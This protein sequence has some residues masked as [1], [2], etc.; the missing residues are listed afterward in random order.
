M[1]IDGAGLG[2]P[3]A[4]KV[5]LT[6]WDGGG[7]DTYDFSNYGTDLKVDINPGGWT[8]TSAAQLASLG[9]SHMARG[10]IA[11]AYL[12]NGNV[13]SLIENVKGGRATTRSPAMSPATPSMAGLGNDTISGGGGS[14]T[15]T[16]G[17]GQGRADR[18][19]GRGQVR[20]Q[21]RARLEHCRHHC[22]LHPWDRQTGG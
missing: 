22:R 8:T 20:I 7:K 17:Y 10:N 21:C 18:R 13:A 1:S 14:D 19:S 11:S 2:A 6:I 12:Y 5:F 9:N 4:N 16:G 3:S 15:L